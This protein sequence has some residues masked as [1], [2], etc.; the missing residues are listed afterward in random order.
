MQQL[1]Q[2]EALQSAHFATAA[3]P[4]RV[5]IASLVE[6]YSIVQTD[7]TQRLIPDLVIQV[8]QRR[9]RR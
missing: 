7:F 9:A 2:T 8:A 3:R 1:E 5:P 4:H 6:P